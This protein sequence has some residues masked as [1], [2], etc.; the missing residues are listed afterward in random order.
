MLK[1]KKMKYQNKYKI[2]IN[3]YEKISLIKKGGFGIVYLVKE[4]DTSKEYA[5]K[6]LLSEEDTPIY[7]QMANREIGIM[8]RVQHP[9]IIQFRG[10]SL[11][12]LDH[13][14]NIVIIMDFARKGSLSKILQDARNS[15]ADKD[16]SN[17]ARQI[18]LIGIAR[19]MMYLHKQH[20][21]H[22]DLKPENVLIDENFH[23]LITDFD[24]S[25]IY[26]NGHSMSQSKACGT[27][28]YMAPEVISGERYNGKSDV[29]AFGILMYEVITESLP[30]P[31]YQNKKISDFNL[32]SKIVNDDYRPE[33]KVPVKPA[34]KKLITQ[35]WTKNPNDRPTFEEIYNKL[36]FNIESSVF[37][38]Y[39]ST[40]SD[41]DED[42]NKYYLD[43]VDV[44]EI[45]CYTDDINDNNIL[46]GIRSK[47]E[48][49]ELSK[50]NEQVQKRLSFFKNQNLLLKDELKKQNEEITSLQE[51]VS[52]LEEALNAG[53]AD[54]K[55]ILKK[56]IDTKIDKNITIQKFN[57]LSFESQK[58]I[59]IN[60]ISNPIDKKKTDKSITQLNKLFQYLSELEFEDDSKYIIRIPFKNSKDKLSDIK[61][62]HLLSNAVEILYK[63]R[64]L[65]STELLN[66][67]N[68][69]DEVF[70][71][72][73]YP[74]KNFQAIYNIISSTQRSK[75]KKIKIATLV[76]K[77]NDVSESFEKYANINLAEFDDSFSNVNNDIFKNCFSLTTVIIPISVVSIGNDSFAGCSAIKEIEIPPSVS[78]IGEK[79]FLAAHL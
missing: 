39:E 14:K 75:L 11:E 48:D 57:D 21:I 62:I 31:N 79:T 60:L 65:N 56:K 3:K 41:A 67:L 10:Y 23:P 77:I 19:G 45:L 1:N 59:V 2:D 71:Q 63:C 8:I 49:D 72:I 34:L 44:D 53:D 37:D 51:R 52:V 28:V 43:D 66:A 70:I 46:C 69:F 55:K 74:L 22:R 25:K 38:I 40:E 26:E 6:V 18:I 78:S 73:K 29:Y 5:A 30:Y 33:F 61:E 20:I 13:N 42:I 27:T 17:T 32:K 12:D 24:L 76:T 7:Q 54:S 68:Q 47:S 36:A 15:L 64:S 35:C 50:F 9:T 58:M 4:K 16:Y